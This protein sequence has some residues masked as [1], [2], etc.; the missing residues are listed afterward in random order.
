M[1]KEQETRFLQKF[2]EA[3]DLP[4]AVRAAEITRGEGYAIL[5]AGGAEAVDRLVQRR[6]S[7]EMLT[8]IRAEYEQIAFADGEKVT[9]RI[10]ALEQLRL[11][12]N[13]ESEHADTS[14]TVRVDYV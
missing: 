7:G 12:A 4:A 9:D 13:G 5:R 2:S 1:T 11:M 8:R 6:L 3:Y 14:L 10:R